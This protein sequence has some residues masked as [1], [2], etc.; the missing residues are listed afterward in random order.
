MIYRIENKHDFVVL[1]DHVLH[2]PIPKKIYCNIIVIYNYI[3]KIYYYIKKKFSN[4]LTFT[5]EEV[6]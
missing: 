5:C 6:L 3:K 2:V 4:I 1:N